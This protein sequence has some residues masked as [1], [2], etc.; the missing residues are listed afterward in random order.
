MHVTARAA[1][2]LGVVLVLSLS[3]LSDALP[4]T[5]QQPNH[6]THHIGPVL[7]TGIG[8]HREDL[9]VPI[10]FDGPVFSLGAGYTVRTVRSCLRLRLLASAALLE[11]RFSHEAYAVA[12]ELRPSWTKLVW[13]GP[14]DR[15]F[16]CGIALP[17]QMRN[18]FMDT[19]DDAHLYW[20]TTHSLAAVGEYHT[21]LP[22]LGYSVVRLDLPIMGLVS[23]PP[24]SR[25]QQQEPLNHV[26]YHFSAPNSSFAF[27][28]IWGYQS[29][30]LQILIRRGSKGA[31]M[32]LGLEF[33]L[34]H[35]PAPQDTW[36]LNTRLLFSYQW[37]IG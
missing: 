29:P 31:L 13:S 14:L 20:L 24:D 27:K 15:Q 32:N 35:C 21:R 11:N 19:W 6:R 5:E 22:Y 3:L 26:S 8:S 30:L 18:L 7:S 4:Q 10:S 33:T 1:K 37:K 34:D 12:L 36:I 9:V 28:S 17:L 23:R 16:W 25:Y 2:Q